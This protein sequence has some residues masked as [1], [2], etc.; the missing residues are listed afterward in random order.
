STTAPWICCCRACSGYSGSTRCTKLSSAACGANFTIPSLSTVDARSTPLPS[1]DSRP[2]P[3][4]EPCETPLCR[5]HRQATRLRVPT[6]YF[7]DPRPAAPSAK[8]AS[9]QQGN[10]APNELPQLFHSQTRRPAR[11]TLQLSP[12]PTPP[13]LPAA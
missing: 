11:L 3:A 2:A 7:R 5:F 12:E 6:R 13:P 8:P 9:Q 10:F 1:P 4:W